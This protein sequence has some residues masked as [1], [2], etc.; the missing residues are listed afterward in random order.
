[1]QHFT[2]ILHNFGFADK[3]KKETEQELQSLS[4]DHIGKSGIAFNELKCIIG[5][6]QRVG[7][8]DEARNCFKIFDKRD[9]GYITAADFKAGFATY[10]DFPVSAQD[11]DELIAFVDKEQ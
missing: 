8:L 4:V 2:N 3:T 11:I 10:L 1:M 9:K 7:K 6:R 5:K